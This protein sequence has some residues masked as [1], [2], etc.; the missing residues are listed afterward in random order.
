MEKYIWLIFS[1]IFLILT[2]FHIYQSFQKIKKIESK[3]QVKSING[4]NVGIHEFIQD[5]NL[6][7]SKFNHQNKRIN[8]ITAIGYFTA[9]LTSIFSYFKSN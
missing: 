7:L 3:A 4:V 8:L 9:F 1:V 6:Y 2:L 5:F